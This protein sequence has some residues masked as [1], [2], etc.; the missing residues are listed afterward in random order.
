M[1]G[2]GLALIIGGVGIHVNGAVLIAL[3]HIGTST[4]RLGSLLSDNG[5]IA[6]VKAELVVII[7]ILALI[8]IV[9]ERSNGHGQLVDHGCV[10]LSCHNAHAVVAGLLDTGDMV[11]RLAGFHADGGILVYISRNQIG[12]SGAG[13][14]GFHLRE[15]P[16]VLIAD[17]QEKVLGSC[18][19]IQRE[20]PLSSCISNGQGVVAKVVHD[21]LGKLYAAIV[22]SIPE[23]LLL[24][25]S[26]VGVVGVVL[27]S[28]SQQ[29][30]QG[31]HAAAVV[32]HA[33]DGAGVEG[34]RA[35]IGGI[36]I[37]IHGEDYIV[38][39]GG[40]AIGELDILAHGNVIVDS[41]VII[42]GDS[43]VS[44]TIV[45]VV[46]TV[47]AAGL[48]LDA[49]EHGVGY[50]VH[51]KQIH[52]GHVRNHLVVNIGCEEGRELALESGSSSN[53][54]AVIA[55]AGF[56][57]LGD[58]GASGSFRSAGRCGASGGCSI[59]AAAGQKANAHANSQ[60]QRKQ[61]GLVFHVKNSSLKI[62]NING[63]S[64]RG[65]QCMMIPASRNPERAPFLPGSA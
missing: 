54:S 39:V 12:Q 25:L 3:E 35:I 32:L 17:G 50:A 13:S 9:V 46:G 55:S 57:T 49:A 7:V 26:P 20:A 8:A 56:N 58:V 10:N 60:K 2:L 14:F 59:V 29:C 42:L 51:S 6:L 23:C 11:S 21:L 62:L 37:D 65:S 4:Q 44:G 41:A 63:Q 28:L 30:R 16:A 36:C 48:T 18:V 15:V 47:V 40:G 45:G 38:D 1:S 27:T 43:D 19:C 31:A 53:Q 22:D 24:F 34:S 33:F 5:Q 52:L 64:V 61:L